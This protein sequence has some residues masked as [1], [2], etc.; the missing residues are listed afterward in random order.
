MVSGQ[1]DAQLDCFHDA[2]G[3]FCRMDWHATRKF[4]ASPAEARALA[5]GATF[6][7]ALGGQ[8]PNVLRPCAFGMVALNLACL[9]ISH[10]NVFVAFVIYLY[11]PAA[12]LSSRYSWVVTNQ[13]CDIDSVHGWLVHVQ[14]I[15]WFLVHP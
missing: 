1:P 14:E 11:K 2:V 10:G 5:C 15:L 8:M 4:A 12:F 7:P 6:S 9:L 3:C 13:V